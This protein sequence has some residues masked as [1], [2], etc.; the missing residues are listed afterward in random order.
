MSFFGFLLNNNS[1]GNGSKMVHFCF[2][3]QNNVF[4]VD[5]AVFN[6]IQLSVN[7][8]FYWVSF[9]LCIKTKT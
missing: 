1:L 3:V 9:N 7:W 4:G 6:A 2:K 8:I 5:K